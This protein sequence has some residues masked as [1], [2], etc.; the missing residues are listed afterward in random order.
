MEALV[1]LGQSAGR[2]HSAGGGATA[3]LATTYPTSRFR[4]FIR[5]VLDLIPDVDR[6]DLTAYVGEGFNI[7]VAQLLLDFGTLALLFVALDRPGLLPHEVA[8]DRGTDV[9]ASA[10]CD[11]R[12]VECAGSVSRYDASECCS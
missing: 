7:P 8:G 1:R 6:Y 3:T 11:Q 12:I 2:S 10:S 9:R 5:R 4:W